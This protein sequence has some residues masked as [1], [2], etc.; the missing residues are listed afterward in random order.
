[1]R[2]ARHVTDTK[3]FPSRLAYRRYQ[4]QRRRHPGEPR[5]ANQRKR[6]REKKSRQNRQGVTAAKQWTTQKF[7]QPTQLASRKKEVKAP[8][9]SRFSIG[10]LET[11]PTLPLPSLQFKVA[12]Q[13]EAKLCK[14]FHWE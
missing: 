8:I 13:K 9:R 4:H 5:D 11:S 14:A 1:V 12:F 6:G 3:S 2:Q 10:R 7:L